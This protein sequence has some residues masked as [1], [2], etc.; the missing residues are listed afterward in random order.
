M[1]ILGEVPVNQDRVFFSDLEELSVIV[2]QGLRVLFLRLHV[3]IGIIGIY[4][5]P[6]IRIR[7]SGIFPGA[8]L[9]RSPRVL[10][11][12]PVD[13]S[14]HGFFRDMELPQ[15]SACIKSLYIPEI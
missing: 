15:D 10:P 2:E 8:P 14:K 9:Y 12:C 4:R 3:Y 7:K 1:V 5:K 11:G 6:G 13:N